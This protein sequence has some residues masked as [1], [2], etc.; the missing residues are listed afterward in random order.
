MGVEGPLKALAWLCSS[1]FILS[2]NVK[3]VLSLKRAW[4]ECVWWWGRAGVWGK[5]RSKTS[6]ARSHG[7]FKLGLERSNM[8]ACYSQE[9]LQ[10]KKHTQTHL[11]TRAQTLSLWCLYS[12]VH[13][14]LSVMCCICTYMYLCSVFY[15]LF[16]DFFLCNTQFPHVAP[17]GSFYSCLVTDSFCSDKRCQVLSSGFVYHGFP[18]DEQSAA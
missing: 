17:K 6:C 8:A 2:P 15:T 1:C 14:L 7:S 5:Q 4:G 3:Q 18:V 16:M 13:R 9:R 12:G 10:P 11:H